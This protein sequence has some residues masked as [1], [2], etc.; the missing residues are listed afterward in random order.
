[1][2]F[3]S[4]LLIWRDK[5]SKLYFH[6]GTLTFDGTKYIF[7][8]THH[9]KANRKVHDAL[10][11]GYRPH[12]AFI[13]LKKKYVSNELFPAFNRRIP[14]ED[15]VDYENILGDLNLSQDADR[16]DILGKTRGVIS[17]DP[18]FF[19]EPLQFDEN[20]N[21]LTTHFYISGMRYRDLPKDWRLQVNTNEKLVV[22]QDLTNE[23]D[24][25]A[26]KIKTNNALWL[27]YIPGIYAQAISSLMKRHIE[28]HV[29]VTEKR[30]DYA[31]QWW[32]RVALEV[33][34]KT[35]G[36]NSFDVDK[37]EGLV[38]GAA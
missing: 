13:D 1:M 25:F 36:N 9:C 26:I 3:K 12:P 28:I 16:M 14:S 5:V 38:V 18:Y 24:P 35:E 27:G 37:F 6:V 7:E 21:K 34:V 30:P 4:L 11:F 22:E 20:N 8:Y 2:T 23:H 33:M 15:R 17:S 32:V 19:E 10:N 31:P 29:T